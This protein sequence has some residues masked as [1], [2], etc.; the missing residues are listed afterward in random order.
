M[1]EAVTNFIVNCYITDLIQF[2]VEYKWTP[3]F[4]NSAPTQHYMFQNRYLT[5]NL[6]QLV[7]IQPPFEHLHL[8]V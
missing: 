3:T 6:L 2:Y 7:R 8:Y 1:F 4:A 5:Q